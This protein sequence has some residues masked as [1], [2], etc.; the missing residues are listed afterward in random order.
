MSLPDREQIRRVAVVEKE[1]SIRTEFEPPTGSVPGAVA[2]GVRGSLSSHTPLLIVCGAA[3]SA[4]E[5]DDPASHVQSL[6]AGSGA[7]RLAAIF[8]RRNIPGRE[9]AARANAKS[10]MANSTRRYT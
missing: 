6:L 7:G 10:S 1:K 8:L 2:G 3:I 9:S 5:I 4:A